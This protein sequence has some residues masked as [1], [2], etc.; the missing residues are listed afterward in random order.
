MW[1]EC[2]FHVLA[3]VDTQSPGNIFNREYQT[4]CRTTLPE[5][6]WRCLDDDGPVLSA[7]PGAASTEAWALWLLPLCFN[8]LED[9]LHDASRDVSAVDT[10]YVA[11]VQCH[12]AVTFLA[13]KHPV[14]VEL[15]RADLALV[16]KVFARSF[17]TEKERVCSEA[18]RRCDPWIEEAQKLVSSLDWGSVRFSAALGRNGRSLMGNIVVGVPSP[19]HEGTPEETVLYA[20]HEHAVIEAAKVLN[21]CEDV[22]KTSFETWH[23]TEK[24]AL[25]ALQEIVRNSALQSP[26]ERWASRFDHRVFSERDVKE[27]TDHPMRLV[28]R[29]RREV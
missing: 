28:R 25:H 7:L 6:A 27:T 12:R 24:L 21:E 18:L 22:P 19:W 1:W 16:G 10:S 26:H 20:L 11:D 5:S 23:T 8:T 2:V 29:L 3:F 14:L 4:W 13:Q 17:A 9:F 15:L